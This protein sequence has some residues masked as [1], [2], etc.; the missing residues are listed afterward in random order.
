MSVHLL[1]D[2]VDSVA[3]D[4]FDRETVRAGSAGAWLADAWRSLAD[5]GMLAALLPDDRG[6][7]GVDPADAVRLLEVVGRRAI[8]LPVSEAMLATGLL[9]RAGVDCPDGV[10]TLA[11]PHRTTATLVRT[12]AGFSIAGRASRVPWARHADIVVVVARSGNEACLVPVPVGACAIKEQANLAGEPRDDVTFDCMVESASVGRA[13][14]LDAFR[15]HAAAAAMRTVMMAGAADR[16]LDTSVEFAR[17]HE[18]FGRPIAAFQAVQQNLAVM[19]GQVALCRAAADMAAAAVFAPD[20]GAAIG[21]AKARAGEAAS[22]VA[23]LAHQVHGAIGFTADHDLHLYSKRVWAWREEFGNEAEWNE[24]VGQ[25]VLDEPA[26]AWALITD[27]AG[28]SR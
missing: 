2:A 19:A 27:P 14:N 20:G 15:I 24:M 6:G 16:L 23:H 7:F 21:M 11:P 26:G 28:Q 3:K 8:P 9:A 25:A 4:L 5:V 1:F 10:T 17:T 12:H 18:Q 13:A 22:G